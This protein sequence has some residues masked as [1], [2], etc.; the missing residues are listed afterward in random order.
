M[1]T[2][3]ELKN[4][5]ANGAKAVLG[6]VLSN[7]KKEFDWIETAFI[8]DDKIVIEESYEVGSDEKNDDDCYDKARENG[9]M[10]IEKFPMLEISNYYC[11]RHKYAIVELRLVQNFA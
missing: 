2:N 7:I 4:E 5:T 3:D 8:E 6:E 11:H 1:S 10:I 9:E